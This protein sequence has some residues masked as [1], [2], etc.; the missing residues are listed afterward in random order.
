MHASQ[1]K[2]PSPRFAGRALIPIVLLAAGLTPALLAQ[3]TPQAAPMPPPHAG[4][5]TL[6]VADHKPLA[7]ETVTFL[8]IETAAAEPA[9][10][11][12]LN[13]PRD[14]GL[15]V[16]EIVPDSPASGVLEPYDILTKFQ[17]QILIES[18]Q[19]AVLVRARQ[20]GDEVQLSLIRGGKELTV[21][22][23]LA[24]HE[25]PKFAGLQDLQ[26]HRNKEAERMFTLMQA[27]R[28][29]FSADRIIIDK[30][31]GNERKTIVNTGHSN[32]IYTDDQGTLEL[33]IDDGQKTLKA[34]GKDGKVVFSGPINTEQERKALPADVL[35]RLKNV[36]SPEH[37]EFRTDENFEAPV[38]APDG[39]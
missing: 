13:L 16:R 1:L 20:P 3:P 22:V 11:K 34:T 4:L 12:Q 24:Q 28:H 27:D 21:K 6:V 30:G 19:L 2:F 9:L 31:D 38:A 26:Q 29:P 33:K 39:M 23:K 35:P 7:K 17:D 8:G 32:V 18:R 36:E 25:V 14:T 10:A 15:V 5:R 37:L